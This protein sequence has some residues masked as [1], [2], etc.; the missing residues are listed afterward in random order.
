[1]TMLLAVAICVELHQLYII[2]QGTVC[3]CDGCKCVH[4]MVIGAEQIENH[5][6]ILYIVVEMYRMSVR[7]VCCKEENF[8]INPWML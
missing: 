7:N 8:S 3:V 2:I 1:M 5:C 6:A 4:L